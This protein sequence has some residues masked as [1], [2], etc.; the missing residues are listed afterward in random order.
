M[1]VSTH[2]LDLACG[3]PAVGVPV[4]LERCL[5]GAETQGWVA[6]TQG[7]V[8]VARGLTDRDGRLRDWTP[9]EHLD[10]GRYRLVFETGRDFFPEV[11][12][13]FEV[14]DPARHLHIPLL[15]SPFGYT[16]Y[17]GS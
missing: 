2:V 15:L 16:T 14:T 3:E 10:P 1:S 8:E 5:T 17:R 11:P 13:V 12:V 6:G 9:A 4:R 7:W